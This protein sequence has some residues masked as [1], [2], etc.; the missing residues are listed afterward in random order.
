[1]TAADGMAMHDPAG[2]AP[3]IRV[4]GGIGVH[5]DDG[6]VSIGG[7]RQRRL[8]ALLTIRVG[9]VVDIDWLAEH[10]WDD[11]DRPDE[12]ARAIRTY[13][14]RLRQALPPAAQAW[15]ETVPGGYRLDAPENAVEH[16]RFAALRAAAAEA[17]DAED[18]LTAHTLLTE[19]IEL[20]R[21]EP[22]R[23]LDDLPWARAEMEQVRLD[24]LEV[25]EG[26]WEAALA[27]GRHTQIIGELAAFT[28]E[29]GDRD[30]AA[31][32]H[33]L[34]L[35]RSGRSA[36]ALRVLADFRR[37]L[38]AESGLDPSP[39]MVE[40][41]RA[42]F[43]DDP[44][45]R[46]ES[47]GRP[48]R[49]YRLLEET[50]A[51][52]FSVVWRG[53][54]P[55]VRRAVAIKQIRAE[56]ASQ[57]DFIRRF[58][59]E[60]HLVARL[61]HP[62][63]V[64]LIDYWRDPDSAY[65]VM[66]WLAGGTLE[67]RL[68]DGPLDLA[69]TLTLAR[70]IGGALT[71]AHDAG[72]VHRDVK[73]A[74]I[75]FDEQGNAFL[76]DFGIAL[77]ATVSA[78][79][80]AALSPGSPLYAAPEQLRREPLGPRADVFSLGVVLFECLAGRLPFPT[81][82][83]ADEV[84]ER[85][86]DVAYPALADL[87]VEVPA[88]VS[89]AVARATEKDA[90]RRFASVAELVAAL[91]GGATASAP[92]RQERSTSELANPYV[93]LRAFDDGDTDRF[94]GRDRLRDEIVGRFAG[95]GVAARCVVVVGPSGSGKS[96]VAR[97]A[98]LP[99]LRDGAAPGSSAWFATTMIPGADPYE[100][101]EA[102]LLRIAVNP[103]SSLLDQLRDGPRG[104]LRGIR[105]CLPSDADHLL[106][107]IDQFE[108]LFVAA[109]AHADDFLDAL[110]VA[111]DDPASP[112]RLLAT[113]RADYYDRPLGH[114]TFAPILSAGAVDV[115]PLA[116]DELERAIVEP[117]TAAGVDFEAGLVARLAAEAVAQP[118]P[119]PLLQYALSELFDRRTGSTR[120]TL[121]AH[122]EIGGLSGALAARSEALFLAAGPEERV[123]IRRVFGRLVDPGAGSADLRRRVP[124]ADLGDDPTTVGV[125]EAFAAARLLTLDRDPV[126][127]EP[128]VEVAHEALL[129]EWPRLVSW[130]AEDRDVLRRVDAI[131]RAATEWDD[132]GRSEADLYR[133]ERLA[134][135]VEASS[136]DRTRL[137]DVDADFLAASEAAASDRARSEERRVRR[138]RRLVAGTAIALT[139]ALVAGGLAVRAQARA[140]DQAEAAELATLISRSA[141]F[142][143]ED[144]TLSL[145]LGLEAH[146]R[147]PGSVTELAVLDAL[148]RETGTSVTPLPPLDAAAVQ[149]CAFAIP[150][151][152]GSRM[153][154]IDGGELRLID[155]VTGDSVSVGPA[156]NL[157]PDG[158]G[159]WITDEELTQRVVA[160]PGDELFVGSIDG[161]D[162]LVI[163]IGSPYVTFGRRVAGDRVVVLAFEREAVEVYD[164]LTGQVIAQ[165]TELG[166]QGAVAL[167][168]DGSLVAVTRTTT[169]GRGE[170]VLIDGVTGSERHRVEI[171]RP[172][173]EVRID[174]VTGEVLVPTATGE[175]VTVDAATGQIVATVLTGATSTIEAVGARPDG[176]VVLLS[177]GQAELI[178]RR[179][180]P[181][182]DGV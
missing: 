3:V 14:S 168:T 164:T 86:L 34:A 78:G 29:H 133:G 43:A 23:E 158:C 72:I 31:R 91:D 60:A 101:L 150:S 123:A 83:S 139:L 15:I 13:L 68:D 8:L 69:E 2:G 147:S 52:A 124:L 162:E 75:L 145:L 174:E 160:G 38:A 142:Q 73:T 163:D 115:T 106:L 135:A 97:A 70:Q 28:A 32:Q 121:A 169:D 85:Q 5:D 39:E 131:A 141:S 87:D 61:E 92:A 179:L 127:R 1:M 148:A 134:G 136:D 112:L 46:V 22:F 107:F 100:A 17:R 181:T 42:L 18:P 130:L 74:N 19:A 182:G 44:S 12:T 171:G 35:H 49:G 10:L 132:G 110:A 146:R 113:L 161:A 84:L 37:R 16:R 94:F 166:A 80:E 11:D 30:R 55:S 170:L 156:P 176:L 104:V 59:A 137:R 154:V 71:T 7:P 53:E 76:G 21:G 152:D 77:E 20:W 111:I 95:A 167:S 151:E 9:T 175:L 178:D 149:P 82:G 144:R 173:E 4:F 114:V 89:A 172:S 153:T 116:A 62:H 6:P 165:V 57:P 90:D 25:Q 65:L 56:L 88:A 102:A 24:R 126:S 58:E 93:G 98:V 27:L 180:G 64:P 117:A 41:E 51:G 33:A 48:L 45:L 50:G 140:N 96:S 128:T 122:D 103:P 66:R 108:E 138:L 119:L 125:I 54:Q 105:R 99:A 81:A 79:P 155:P 129:R 143:N 159:A 36:E 118:A 177:A 157:G 109:G 67:R 47:L 26:R 40:L 120:L 63:I